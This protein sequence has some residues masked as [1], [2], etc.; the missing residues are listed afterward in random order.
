MFAARSIGSG[1]SNFEHFERKVENLKG[2]CESW[3][4]GD[5]APDPAAEID[6]LG[7]DDWLD[8]ELLRTKDSM[9]GVDRNARAVIN[10]Q[11]K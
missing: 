2:N 7:V 5:T 4:C 1:F 6:A 8:D 3:I 11:G 10:R 9:A